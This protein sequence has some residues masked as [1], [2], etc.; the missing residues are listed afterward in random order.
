ME[1]QPI[2][3]FKDNLPEISNPEQRVITKLDSKVFSEP[4]SFDQIT[5]DAYK[6]NQDKMWVAVADGMGGGGDPEAASQFV[7]SELG[8]VLEGIN[9]E[10][11]AQVKETQNQLTAGILAINN[12]L[13]ANYSKS[14]V[15]VAGFRVLNT[16]EGSVCLGINVGDVRLYLQ[17]T[18]KFYL[19]SLDSYLQTESWF[20][21]EEETRRVL[22]RADN[23][24]SAEDL[25]K[26]VPKVAELFKIRQRKITPHHLG[27]Y[28]GNNRLRSYLTAFAVYP[29]DKLLLTTDGLWSPL[30]IN[31]LQSCVSADQD[32]LS[33][34]RKYSE[35]PGWIRSGTDDMTG[36]LSSL[37]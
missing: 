37:A 4:H 35:K 17:R 19:M 16:Q 11:T 12:N 22:L 32:L 30:T 15:A 25:N 1:L 27:N 5:Q 26:V 18:D 6:Y 7:V 34:A 31:Q 10:N 21:S 14:G 13:T 9:L 23:I 2:N 24:E 28:F 36:V 33:L 20:S 3:L 8:S 29:G